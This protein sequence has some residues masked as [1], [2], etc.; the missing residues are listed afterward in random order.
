MYMCVCTYACVK[1]VQCLRLIVIQI[2]INLS[3]CFWWITI[4][5]VNYICRNFYIST[6]EYI[7][8]NCWHI[9][10]NDE[11]FTNSITHTHT[12]VNISFNVSTCGNNMVSFVNQRTDKRVW[13]FA[14]KIENKMRKKPFN[15]TVEQIQILRVMGG[16][17][18]KLKVPYR[19]V[20][21]C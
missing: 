10:I 14:F 5:Y 12:L 15:N 11:C 3:L 7:I 8:S 6:N 9:L 21:V 2:I 13:L 18:A 20:C 17:M 1:I 4:K 19:I 16:N